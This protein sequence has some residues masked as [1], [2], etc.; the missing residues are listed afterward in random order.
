M[1]LSFLFF[2]LCFLGIGIY[3]ATQKQSNTEDYLLA[4]RSVSPWLTALSAVSSNNSGFMFIGMIGATYKEGLSSMWL[5]VGW[6]SG[7]YL[8]WRFV[9]KQLRERSEQVGVLSIPTFLGAQ[10]VSGDKKASITAESVSGDVGETSPEQT[11]VILQRAVVILA[12]LATLL[13]LGTYAAA[14]LTAGSKA[15]HV[16]FDWNL[17]TGTLIGAGIVATYCFS[18]G[19]RASIWTDAAQSIVM[20]ASMFLLL[21]VALQTIGGLDVL[22]NKLEG[23]DPALIDWQP[24]NVRFGFGLY[25]VGWI[26][27]GLGVLGQP[28]IMIRAMVIDS[29]KSISR[30][31]RIYFSWYVAFAFA[32]VLTGLCCRV[33]LPETEAVD[34]ELAL[35][36]LSQQ[37]LPDVLVGFIL[38][39]L[40]AATVST[41]DS[42]ILSC[43]AALTQDLF[44][45]WGHSYKFTKAGTIIITVAVIEIVMIGHKSVF[46]LVILSWS[47]LASS[48]GP[49]LTVRAMRKTVSNRVGVAMIVSG[50]VAVL[51]WRYALGL[52]DALYEVLP[53]MAAGFL[54]YGLSR[55]WPQEQSN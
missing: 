2:L 43:S 40:F 42:Q 39:G 26:V 37:L 34:P 54:V 33:L 46:E 9:F 32:T 29:A 24:K 17:S 27:A 25:L 15:L 49:L 44:P 36:H 19:I 50:I 1:I 5:M 8:A 47:G 45:R 38:A 13:F 30:A 28:H 4:G 14:Q 23:I 22:W 16:L 53:G 3:S 7:D 20:L 48:L 55:L 51:I 31:R 12:A 41:A 10:V 6:I 35:P 52:S 11:K 18:G 21:I